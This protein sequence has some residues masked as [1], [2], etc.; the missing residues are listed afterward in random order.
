[1]EQRVEAVR[2]FNRFYT[3][4]I[5]VVTDHYLDLPFSLTEARVIYELA[6]QGKL[7]ATAL[8]GELGLDAG[9]LSRILQGFEKRQLVAKQRSE[10]DGR[11]TLLCLTAEGKQV[12][13]TLNEHSRQGIETLLSGLP[14]QDDQKRLIQAMQTIESVLAPPASV[15]VPFLLRPHQ[16]GDLGWVIQR[17]GRL[18]AEEYGWDETFE[19]FVAEIAAAFIRHFN[20]KLE[21][22]WLAE[23]DGETIG[24]VVLVQHEPQVAKLRLLLVEPKARGYGVG[25]R[26]VEE[27]VRF[28]RMAGYQKILLW[29]NSILTA[30]RQ[31]YQKSGFQLIESEPHHSFGK[32]L[33]GETWELLL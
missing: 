3:K 15:A 14:T 10:T 25:T 24:S 13:A 1:M 5:G 26:L 16:P 28:A 8:R 6:Q 11:Q 18:Y 31:I 7:T 9:Y 12:F 23:K 19:A 2:H 4:Q 20:P 29:T 27:C 17:H 22:C 30:A 33:I 32:D 21:C